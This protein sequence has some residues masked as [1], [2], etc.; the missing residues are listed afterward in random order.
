MAERYGGRFSPGAEE[1][2]KAKAFRNA[3][4]DPV[5]ARSN[6]MFVPP[7][8]LAFFSLGAGATGLAA[9]LVGAAAWFLGAWLLRDGMRAE[10][11]Y[12]SRKIAQR[13]ALPRK[14]LAAGLAGVGM[15][16]AALKGDTGLVPAVIYGVA[17]SGLHVAAFGLDPFRGKGL[18]SVD[19]FQQDRVA[20]VVDEAETYLSGMLAAARRAGDRTVEGRVEAFCATARELIRT[21]EE[22][23]RDLSAARKYLGVYLMGARDAAEKF[24][25]IYS[26]SRDAGARTDFMMLLTDL[27]ESFGQKTRTLLLDNNTD[28]QLEIDVLRDRLK[29]EGVRLDTGSE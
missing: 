18:A 2:A 23:P 6:L 4:V 29:R 7:V 26:R 24:A 5:G 28:L 19:S 15:V 14:T 10:A 27:E 9:G 22:D 16:F 13:P 20:R 1:T 25:D 12:H 21:V 8:V 11:E 3:R 17:A